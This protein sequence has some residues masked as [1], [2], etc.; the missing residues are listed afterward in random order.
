MRA[1]LLVLLLLIARPLS[2]VTL[3][4]ATAGP[5]DPGGTATV[6]VALDTGGA[7][8]AG[9]Q[10]DLTWDGSC[11]TL[12]DTSACYASGTHGK[13]LQGKLLD[14]RDFTY[15]ALIL[16]L[17]DVDPIDDGVLYCC[18][19]FVEATAGECCRVDVTGAGASDP[20][21]NALDVLAVGGQVCAEPESAVTPIVIATP[22]RTPTLCGSCPPVAND[23][24]DG[25]QVAAPASGG[26]AAWP[27]V[28]AVALALLRRRRGV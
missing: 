12:P 2:A 21:G 4:A 7:Q 14:N 18:D 19:F 25:C 16:S 20:R 9:T 11:L 5:A 22:T 1:S 27:L 10:N 6:C 24:D 23:E 13:Q 8:V 28:A 3:T 17:S 26:S 15:R